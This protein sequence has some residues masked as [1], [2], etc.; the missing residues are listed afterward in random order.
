MCS[1]E[2]DFEPTVLCGLV[3]VGNTCYANS[4]LQALSA[5]AP[6]VAALRFGAAT[7]SAA[8]SNERY[9]RFRLLTRY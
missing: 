7:T 8:S 3:N 9:D 1:M 6:A 4:A 5:C 2:D